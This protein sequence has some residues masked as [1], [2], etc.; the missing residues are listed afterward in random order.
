MGGDSPK[1]GQR[2]DSLDGRM[3]NMKARKRL[4]C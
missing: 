2:D 3:N 1:A 4:R